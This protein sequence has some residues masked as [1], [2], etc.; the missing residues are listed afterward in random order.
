MCS[1][2][3]HPRMLFEKWELFVDDNE[4]PLPDPFDY[5]G[6]DGGPWLPLGEE[7]LDPEGGC[8]CVA[9]G[10]LPDGMSVTEFTDMVNSTEMCSPSA[11]PRMLF[12]K[13]QLFVD[14]NEAPLPDP[15]DYS[16]HD[17]SLSPPPKGK[18][19]DPEARCLSV[20]IVGLPDG[21]SARDFIDMVNLTEVVVGIHLV[22]KS[23]GKGPP[24][25]I[26]FNVSP[27]T[28]RIMFEKGELGVDDN[29]APLPEPFDLVKQ[30]DEGEDSDADVPE[31]GKHKARPGGSIEV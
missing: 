4:A 16:D 6:H 1:P 22:I 14:D 29:E 28:A 7:E 26:I 23:Q 25:H 13:W 10:G 19:P 15:F 5:F 31:V 18:E 17:N 12:E 2:P 8:N 24:A 9:V 21:V 30:C 3:S 11:H 27:V 20:V